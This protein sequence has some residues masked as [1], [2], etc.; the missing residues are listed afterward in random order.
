MEPSYVIVSIA[1]AVGEVI[2]A[3]AR[4][5]LIWQ[6]VFCLSSEGKAS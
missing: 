3:F 4:V 1:P 5:D 2:D 6:F